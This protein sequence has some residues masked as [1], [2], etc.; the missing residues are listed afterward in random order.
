MRPADH[1]TPLLKGLRASGLSDAEIARR[2]KR[3]M[4]NRSGHDP[5]ALA[6]ELFENRGMLSAP[7]WPDAAAAEIA[8]S[9]TPI[10][11]PLFRASSAGRWA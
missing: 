8:V 6:S 4:E 11:S 3:A 10:P 9:L 5:L 1:F 2:K 7:Y